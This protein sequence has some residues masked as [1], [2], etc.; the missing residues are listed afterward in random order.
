MDIRTI[1]LLTESGDIR[2]PAR[3]DARDGRHLR[4]ALDR[5]VDRNTAVRIDA[6]DQIL[7]GE[8]TSCGRTR[9]GFTAEVELDQA[10]TS[11]HDLSRLV[12]ALTGESRC[13]SEAREASPDR[14]LP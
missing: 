13:R 6:A 2:V 11:V 14:T 1:T 9:D 4:L 3:V 5:P 10:I 7:L 8:V 12:A